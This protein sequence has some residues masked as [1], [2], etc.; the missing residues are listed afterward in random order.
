MDKRKENVCRNALNEIWPPLTWRN[1]LEIC[2]RAS[3]L[4]WECHL[5]FDQRYD[6][7]ARHTYVDSTDI[8]QVPPSSMSIRLNIPSLVLTASVFAR[9]PTAAPTAEGLYDQ[10]D[11][12][13]VS[14]NFCFSLRK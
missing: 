14:Q 12:D 8:L 6:L 3:R 13:M 9:I 2:G 7:A 1:C 4:D 11:Q 5:K 10:A